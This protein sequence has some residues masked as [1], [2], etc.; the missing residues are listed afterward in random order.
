MDVTKDLEIWLSKRSLWIQNAISRIINKGYINEED[1]VQLVELCK[2][3]AGILKD[4]NGELKEIKFNLRQIN[5]EEITD[6][7]IIE[8]I[9][10]LT[11]MFA[12]APRKPLELG[13]NKLTAVYGRNGSGKSSYVKVL[14][15]MCG[16]IKPGV[17]ISNIFED[18]NEIKG[19]NIDIKIGDKRESICWKQEDGVSDRLKEIEIY[20]TDCAD[21][22]VNLENEVTY[23]PWIL[24]LLTKLTE[25]CTKVG[26]EIEKEIKNNISKKPNIPK[27]YID[28]EVGKLY[29]NM[30][31]RSKKDVVSACEWNN[32]LDRKLQILKERLSVVNPIEKSKNLSNKVNSLNKLIKSIEELEIGLSDEVC[33]KY[34]TLK[35]EADLKRRVADEDVDKVLNLT[36]LD[37]IGTE[38]WKLLWEQAR[39]YS[40]KLAYK[41]NV[42]PN[43]SESAKCVLCQQPLDDGAKNRLKSFEAFIKGSIQLQ[44]EVAEKN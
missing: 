7:L 35:K 12:L 19:C 10:N 27:E 34:L 15:H 4:I 30:S 13:K 44:A 41:D 24:T 39:Q 36:S 16:A 6:D 8:S 18:K 22:Y 3:E 11:G 26:E 38:S 17:L 37:G 23:E 29:L 21:V 9:S 25:V 40:E 28:T 5:N 20:D 14:K 1:I 2:K 42:F 31:Y 33:N 32:E 43:V